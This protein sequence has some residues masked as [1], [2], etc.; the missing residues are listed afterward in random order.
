MGVVYF[1]PEDRNFPFSDK[2]VIRTLCV[3][4]II[5]INYYTEYTV[6]RKT[7]TI[8]V[9]D[10]TIPSIRFDKNGICNQY[11]L[12]YKLDKRYPINNYGKKQFNKIRKRILKHAKKNKY[13]CIVRLS[14][15]RDSTYTILVA[16]RLGFKP[17]ALHFDNGWVSK[18][19]IE[20]IKKTVKKLNVDIRT[21]LYPKCHF[22]RCP[23]RA[24]Q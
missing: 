20:N 8:C 23:G 10:T 6:R 2:P 17:L 19:A 4:F 15:G 21:I 7:C 1:K 5:N 11:A 12:H 16:K 9:C 3:R 24:V 22:L 18:T 14:G 13:G